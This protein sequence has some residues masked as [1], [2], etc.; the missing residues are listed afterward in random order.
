MEKLYGDISQMKDEVDKQI[1][2]ILKGILPE[3]KKIM[4][5]LCTKIKDQ[6]QINIDLQKDITKIKKRNLDI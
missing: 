4:N 2:E 3:Y 1:D 6:R 5:D